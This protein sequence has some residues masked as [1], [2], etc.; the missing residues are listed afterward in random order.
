[1]F[2]ENPECI[3]SNTG[4]CAGQTVLR[5]SLTGTGTPI[6]RCDRHWEKRLDLESELNQRYPAHPP[7]DWDYLDA[8][9][10]WYEDY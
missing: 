9:E 5:E 4:E 3:E 6:P 8:G 7:A 1:M 10:H 2:G